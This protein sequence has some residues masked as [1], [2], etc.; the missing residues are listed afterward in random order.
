M[1]DKQLKNKKLLSICI[2][3]Y[4]RD[5]YLLNLLKILANEA[6][7]VDK[8]TNDFEIC[9]SDN[10][11]TDCTQD[12]VRSFESLLPIYSKKNKDNIG[13]GMNYLEVVKMSTGEY[14]WVIGDDDKIIEG[15]L[16]YILDL[17]NK[18]KYDIYHVK[19]LLNSIDGN[20]L[21]FNWI[22]DER[23]LSKN[24]YD[25]FIKRDCLYGTGFIGSNIFK[26]NNICLEKIGAL[27]KKTYWPQ[28]FLLLQQKSL[29]KNAY[30][31]K[32]LLMQGIDGIS[33]YWKLE[34]W[35]IVKFDK[36]RIVDQLY[37][38]GIVEGNIA[39][40]LVYKSLF[41]SKELKDIL[42]A[43]MVNNSNLPMFIEEMRVHLLNH[44]KYRK[45]IRFKLLLVSLL[46]S[47]VFSPFIRLLSIYYQ[48]LIMENRIEFKENEGFSRK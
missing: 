38:N 43:L 28:H 21:Y 20:S 17:I 8:Y 12:I 40:Y 15:S 47:W 45:I 42:L 31:T 39:N 44:T 3:T 9:I 4:N 32:P 2:P 19:V 23:V 10:N 37:H 33:L 18:T 27:V 30:I 26:R 36:V 34:N 25:A 22:D 6:Q 7:S 29:V 1:S 46:A 24:E 48:D 13:A 41:S 5:E 14:V 11:S 16:L 35:L